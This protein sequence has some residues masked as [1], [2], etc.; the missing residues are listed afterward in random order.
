M[1]ELRLCMPSEK[2]K[3]LLLEEV[4][5]ADLRVYDSEVYSLR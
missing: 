1:E 5:M 3:K 2:E 4:Y